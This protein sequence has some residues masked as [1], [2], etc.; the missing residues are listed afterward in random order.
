[1]HLDARNAKTNNKLLDMLKQCKACCCWCCKLETILYV[2]AAANVQVISSSRYNICLVK[3]NVVI[4]DT[5][6]CRFEFGKSFPAR[7]LA[8]L[9]TCNEKLNKTRIIL[10][11]TKRLRIAIR[12]SGAILPRLP[13][14]LDGARPAKNHTDSKI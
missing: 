8:V 12:K 10:C 13:H 9:I 14:W 4:S 2:S 7:K 1:M 6:E 3:T 11:Y 5:E